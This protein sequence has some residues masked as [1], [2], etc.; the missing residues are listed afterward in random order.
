MLICFYWSVVRLL[1]SVC[2]VNG[3]ISLKIFVDERHC[4]DKLLKDGRTDHYKSHGGEGDFQLALFFS[5]I[6]FLID[7][8]WQVHEFS[9]SPLHECLLHFLCMKFCFSL[10]FFILHTTTFLSL[11]YRFVRQRRR[12]SS[13]PYAEDSRHSFIDTDLHL[14]LAVTIHSQNKW[15]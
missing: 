7:P 6:N 3:A 15:P 13:P 11:L 4:A 14:L 10:F 9:S 1:V 8:F 5:S 2:I 12:G